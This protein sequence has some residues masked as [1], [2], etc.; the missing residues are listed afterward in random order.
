MSRPSAALRALLITSLPVLA[1]LPAAAF[2]APNGRVPAGQLAGVW[3]PDRDDHSLAQEP[4]A[5]WNTL[6]LCAD[7]DGLALHGVDKPG[8]AY[9]DLARQRR[10]F[11]L[12]G[13][14]RGNHAA[15]PGRSNHGAGVAIDLDTRRMRAWLDDHGRRL[16]WAKAWSDAPGE[17]W[18]IRYR[19]GVWDRRP[20]P[21]ALRGAPRLAEG[22]GGPCQ[23]PWVERLQ[24]LL[25][26]HGGAGVGAPGRFGPATERSLLAF[27]R[28][29]GLPGTG[30]TDGATWTALSAAP[31]AGGAIA[32]AAAGVANA[33][34]EPPASTAAH[35]RRALRPDAL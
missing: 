10:L 11:E 16:G 27:Q 31:P 18:H 32:S 9:R 7:A 13:E 12:F 5:A 3:H 17:W 8:S 35:S 28:S 30:E 6:R 34:A 26:E 21:G 24:E 4:A 33:R 25:R 23:A 14:G 29:L 20:D 1:A 22:S 2:A 19:A 15:T